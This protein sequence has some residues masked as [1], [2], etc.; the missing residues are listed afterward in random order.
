[1]TAVAIAALSVL[2][3]GMVAVQVNGAVEQQ[4]AQQEQRAVLAA[5]AGLGQAYMALQ[6]GR[7][8][9]LGSAQQPVALASGDVFVTTQTFGPSNRLVRVLASA[10]V[11]TSAARAELLLR[12]NVNTKFVW[13]AFGDTR[14]DLSSQA[15][16]DSYDSTLGTYA[17]Q[18]VHGSGSNSWANDKGNIG[19]NGDISI[20]Q[21]ALVFGDAVPGE[22]ATIT[23]LGSGTVS[24]STANATA[25]TVLPPIVVPVIASSGDRTFA[26]DTTLAS[27]QH[28]MAT[29][30]ISNNVTVTVIGP[31]TLVFD[32]FVMKSRSNLRIDSTN[33]PV[34]IYVI[35]DF[36][37]NSNTL[38]ASNDQDPRAVSLNLISNN[39]LNPE[40]LVELDDIAFESNAKLYGTVYA[41]EARISIESNFELFG[42]VVA[43]EV[44]LASNARVHYDEALARVLAPGTARY[45]RVTWR[46]MH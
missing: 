22:S 46:A 13:G 24:G 6:N 28:H 31:A 18:V 2:A 39:I 7:S 33:G 4:R 37:M 40:V 42:A 29:T 3:L 17:S 8:G 45:T 35:N 1:M 16:V 34:E 19:S 15:K 44:N 36:V 12:D 26:V 21:N 5:E 14:L 23:I 32:S 38:L 10:Q 27:G 43:K 20:Q 30:Q 41:P 25:G 9:D 11:G